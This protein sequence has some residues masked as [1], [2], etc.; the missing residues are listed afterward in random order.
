M[1][2]FTQRVIG[3]ARLD[4]HTYEEVEADTTAFPQ[5]WN[6]VML[7]SVAAGIGAAGREGTPGLLVGTVAA[8]VSWLLWAWLAYFIGTRIL[9]TPQT[10]ADW[11]Q[12]LRTTGF[13]AAPGVFRLVGV[14]PELTALVFLIT[15]IWMLATFVIAVRQALDYTS[16][17]RAI[18][19][20]SIGWLAYG[21]IF[22]VLALLLRRN[23][24]E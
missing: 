8:L 14:V 16:T 10:Q 9:P 17:W 24:P 13:A 11:G 5:A 19:V 23:F 7:S 18:A 6:V 15:W 4:V 20:C 3:A 1:A 12:L 2:T 21:A 22:S